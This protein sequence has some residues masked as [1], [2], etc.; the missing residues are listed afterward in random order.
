LPSTWFHSP[1]IPKVPLIHLKSIPTEAYLACV[2]PLPISLM[3][4]SLLR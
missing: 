4:S 3:K 2:S 1:Q